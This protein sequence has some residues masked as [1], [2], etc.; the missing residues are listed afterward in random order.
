MVPDGV[1]ADV[2]CP[3]DLGRCHS[4]GG[5]AEYFKFPCCYLT[6]FSGWFPCLSIWFHGNR[7]STVSTALSVL[8]WLPCS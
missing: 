8:A 6:A 1:V 3:R 5:Q 4:Q 7:G 2:Q